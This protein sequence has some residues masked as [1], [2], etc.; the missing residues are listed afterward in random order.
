MYPDNQDHFCRIFGFNI[1]MFRRIERERE[2]GKHVLLKDFFPP[3]ASL[4]KLECLLT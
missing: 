4:P 3:L 1:L 2:R